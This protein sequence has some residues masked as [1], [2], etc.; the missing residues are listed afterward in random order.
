MRA[1]ADAKDGAAR[2]DLSKEALPACSRRCRCTRAQCSAARL[3]RDSAKPEVGT[4]VT[5]F[6]VNGHKLYLSA[7]MDL[8]N[9]EII[10]HRMAR[11]PVFELVSSTLQAALSR[12]ECASEL[13]VH[14]DQG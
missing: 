1:A 7:C 9:G 8:Y 2:I 5:E 6:N 3:L 10:A 11:R 12:T 13:I 4:D 14:S